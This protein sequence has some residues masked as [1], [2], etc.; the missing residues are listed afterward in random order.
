VETENEPVQWWLI[1]L[2]G[3]AIVALAGFMLIAFGGSAA[4]PPEPHPIAAAATPAPPPKPV[5]RVQDRP[6]PPKLDAEP[7]FARA[8]A[9]ETTPARSTWYQGGN[10]HNKTIGEWKRATYANRLAT[11]GDIIA[12]IYKDLQTEQTIKARAVILENEITLG[13]R[14]IASADIYTVAETAGLAIAL[15][16]R[17]LGWGR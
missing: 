8:V 11:C 15:L 17:K 7:S 4:P 3:S 2:T 13:V 5:E 10:L 12:K 1:G 16:E 14:G 9:P 6:A